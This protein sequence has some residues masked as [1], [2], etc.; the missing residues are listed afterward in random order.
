[1]LLCLAC[2]SAAQADPVAIEKAHC[3]A[4]DTLTET[5]LQGQVPWAD[6]LSGRAAQGYHCNLS[7]VSQTGDVSEDPQESKIYGWANFDTYKTCAYFGDGN[8]TGNGDGGTV[9]MDV[10]DPAHPKQTAYLT[11]AAMQ[12]PWESLRVNAKRGLLVADHQSSGGGAD[13]AGSSPL[14]VYDV[15]QD[16]THPKLLF[17]GNMPHGIGHEGWFSPDGTI[18]WMSSIGTLTPVDLS[19]PSHP[20][21]LAA[22]EV[23]THGGSSSDDGTRQYLCATGGASGEGVLIIDST[24]IQKH[25]KQTEAPREIGFAPLPD[26]AACQETYPVTYGNH[27]Y[28]I[29]FGELPSNTVPTCNNGSN[30]TWSRPH[31]VDIADEKNPKV[32]STWNNEVSDPANCSMV[33]GDKTT[34]KNSNA[35]VVNTLF[36]YGTH[37]C[38][39]D[40]LHDP[41]LMTCA[42]F[43]SGMRVYD[44][45]D[46][47]HPKEIAYWNV[48]T[49]SAANPEVDITPARAVIRPDTG[50][51]WFDPT[52][53]GFHV[54]QFEPGAGYPFPDSRTCAPVYDYF[55]AQYDLSSQCA[56]PAAAAAPAKVC[57]RVL[58]VKL[59]SVVGA[60][61]LRRLRSARV[62]VGGKLVRRVGRRALKTPVVLRRL[63]GER[64]VVRVVG[65]AKGG[66]RVSARRS[67]AL[68][69]S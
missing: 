51:I 44:I 22:W 30:P 4:A 8:D 60:K 18:Y 25:V 1:M 55:F 34:S 3:S 50:Q 21:E 57:Q 53:S 5:G 14:D 6:R 16:C 39:P 23:S 63:S 38:H 62:Y 47:F 41:T 24:G 2:A 19:D 28:V 56:P 42:E 31:L 7:L 54:V 29:Q 66:K 67:F 10:S 45:R 43:H 35:R 12:G 49:L 17:S 65:R 52:F 68:C 69:A 26:N 33:A 46:P 61:R 59:G 27:P 48:G 37:M 58:V 32:V 40:R 9:V 13:T 64:V 36:G 11:T 15:S 20:V